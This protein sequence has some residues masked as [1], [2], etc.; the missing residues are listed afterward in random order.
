MTQA[1]TSSAEA[2]TSPDALRFELRGSFSNKVQIADT[3]RA[4]Y[5]VLDRLSDGRFHELALVYHEDFHVDPNLLAEFARA[6]REALSYKEALSF[7][8]DIHTRVEGLDRIQ[9]GHTRAMVLQI[10]QS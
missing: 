7:G 8:R 9:C 10:H 1:P 5:D 2:A 6:A 3:F 4:A